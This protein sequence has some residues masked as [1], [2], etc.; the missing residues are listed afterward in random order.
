MAN[1]FKLIVISPES[2][3]FSGDVVSVIAPAISGLVGVRRNHAPFITALKS[4]EVIYKIDEEE[5]HI[6][7]SGGILE[8]KENVMTICVE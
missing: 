2:K 7:I 1:T 8:M 6:T 4:G 3:L 5:K